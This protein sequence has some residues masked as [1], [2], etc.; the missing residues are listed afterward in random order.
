MKKGIWL[1]PCV[2]VFSAYSLK[3]EKHDP[4]YE[5]R[6]STVTVYDEVIGEYRQDGTCADMSEA[7]NEARKRREI[8][9]HGGLSTT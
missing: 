9:R 4:R 3:Y 6:N 8:E 7:L 2:V 5:V 1:L